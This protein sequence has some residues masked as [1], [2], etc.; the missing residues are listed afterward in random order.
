MFCPF[1]F[2]L[3]DAAEIPVELM[4]YFNA[5]H[6]ELAIFDRKESALPILRVFS[7]KESINSAVN[8]CPVIFVVGHFLQPETGYHS[9][10]P[11][12][13]SVAYFR[14]A[15]YVLLT[16]DGERH[17][18]LQHR[19]RTAVEVVSDLPLIYPLFISEAVPEV[20][21]IACPITVHVHEKYKLSRIQMLEQPPVGRPIEISSIIYNSAHPF[22]ISAAD[23]LCVYESHFL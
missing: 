1:C 11:Y 20:N 6:V 17:H 14:I 16:P 18:H 19:A 8:L 4:P 12:S 5:S 10:K 13:R 22:K 7:V 2:S 15:H 21:S 3:S 9:P 23:H